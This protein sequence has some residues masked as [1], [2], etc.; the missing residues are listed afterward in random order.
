[1]LNLSTNRRPYWQVSPEKRL[2]IRPSIDSVEDGVRCH[3]FIRG[4]HVKWV[5]DS[6]PRP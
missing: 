1:M 5:A 6:T 3:F 4:G 2:T